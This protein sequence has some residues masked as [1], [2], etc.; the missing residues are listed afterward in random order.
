LRELL[1]QLRERELLDREPALAGLFPRAFKYPQSTVVE[2]RA[3]LGAAC[4]E[5]VT[6]VVTTTSGGGIG[7]GGVDPAV[8][9]KGWNGLA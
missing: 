2:L 4:L 1:E 9:T 6:S 8:I 3:G 7:G 5:G